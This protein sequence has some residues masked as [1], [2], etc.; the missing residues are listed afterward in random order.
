MDKVQR[1]VE[2]F[3]H[4]LLFLSLCFFA[5]FFENLSER[6]TFATN[7]LKSNNL[8]RDKM[9]TKKKYVKRHHNNH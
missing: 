4:C 8:K 2:N 6:T 7:Y 1:N 5:L 3:V 9:A